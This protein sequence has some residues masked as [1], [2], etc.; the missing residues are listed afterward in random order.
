MI[1][2]SF[3]IRTNKTYN[4]YYIIYPSKERINLERSDYRYRRKCADPLRYP[5]PFHIR[6]NLTRFVE[7]PLRKK[8]VFYTN[9]NYYWHRCQWKERERERESTIKVYRDPSR[10]EKQHAS[11]RNGWFI[12]L[13]TIFASMTCYSEKSFWSL[14]LG[15][16]FLWKMDG[17]NPWLIYNFKVAEQGGC[18]PRL[19]KFPRRWID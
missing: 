9:W 11:A 6:R 8:R 1:N 14:R 13:T 18:F 12:S 19:E 5:Y 16:T 10:R 15:K 3:D 7:I 17:N 2:L 4:N